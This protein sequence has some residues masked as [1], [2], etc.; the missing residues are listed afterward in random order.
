M[1][2]N[3][4][5]LYL[6]FDVENVYQN[7]FHYA[8]AKPNSCH[9]YSPY[10]TIFSMA[11]KKR[12]MESVI[13]HD[14]FNIHLFWLF[15]VFVV[16]LC[17]FVYWFCFDFLF[18]HLCILH[19]TKTKSLNFIPCACPSFSLLRISDTVLF[20]VEQILFCERIECDVEPVNKILLI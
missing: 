10:A 8:L 11:H 12:S 3:M 4:S 18:S 6:P 13:S 16:C 1:A 7:A 9:F 14:I 15:L 2:A 17:F 5:A 20:I 19:P